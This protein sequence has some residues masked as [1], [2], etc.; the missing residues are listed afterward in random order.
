MVRYGAARQVWV[1]FG[2]VRLAMDP[3]EKGTR[4][5]DWQAELKAL[6]GPVGKGTARHGIFLLTAAPLP[7]VSYIVVI[8]V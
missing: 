5:E 6:L 3:K 8:V 1:G 4:G 7:D 2:M